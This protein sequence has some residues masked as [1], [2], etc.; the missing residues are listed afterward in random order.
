[1]ES[2]RMQAA[3]ATN[4]TSYIPKKKD[5]FKPVIASKKEKKI[6]K[7]KVTFV[8]GEQKENQLSKAKEILMSQSD[9]KRRSKAKKV[10]TE[11]ITEEE[12]QRKIDDS[13]KLIEIEKRKLIEDEKKKKQKL[14]HPNPPVVIFTYGLGISVCKGCTKKKIEHEEITYPHNM[15]FQRCRIVGYYNKILNKFINGEVNVHFHLKKSC[16]RNADQ[17]VEFKDITMTDEVF[18]ALSSEQMEVLKNAD[19]LQYILAN[20]NK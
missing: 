11:I 18:A 16:L 9:A 8:T 14:V 19:I 17:T 1:M 6:K 2:V 20:K 13:F 4:P 10:P 3:E 15:V 5:H 7:R 12:I